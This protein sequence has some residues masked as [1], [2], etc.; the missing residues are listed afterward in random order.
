M[1]RAELTLGDAGLYALDAVVAA[2]L[3]HV[4]ERGADMQTENE[5]TV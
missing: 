1:S 5:L 2:V 3:S 4:V